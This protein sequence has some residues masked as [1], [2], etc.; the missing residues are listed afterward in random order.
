MDCELFVDIVYFDVELRQKV[1]N[2]LRE[3][4]SCRNPVRVEWL[5][6]LRTSLKGSTVNPPL[7]P[8][9]K[10]SRK[11]SGKPKPSPPPPREVTPKSP[12]RGPATPN[13]TS[14]S[15]HTQPSPTDPPN[16]TK[17]GN[18]TRA[19]SQT[20]GKNVAPEKVTQGGPPDSVDVA[21]TKDPSLSQ[22]TEPEPNQNET[23]RPK[24]PPA[25]SSPDKSTQDPFDESDIESLYASPSP[26]KMNVELD[27]IELE[28]DP[29]FEMMERMLLSHRGPSSQPQFIKKEATA[30]SP[31]LFGA[32]RPLKRQ[33][34]LPSPIGS[35]QVPTQTSQA[36][37]GQAKRP[38]VN[39]PHSSVSAMVLNDRKK[40][41]EFWDLD[42]TVVLQ[43]DDVLFRVMR[44]TLSKASPWFQRLF[45]EEPDHLEIMA[46]CRVYMIE[47]D[48][49]HLDFAN[50]L[51]GLEN[52][53]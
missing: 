27:P 3:T 20:V 35:S 38:R 14:V 11:S 1:E 49:G 17:S 46:G 41:P 34:S 25:K 9:L 51:R 24:G 32:K 44:S 23:A 45:S 40:H 33:R 36:E 2:H 37:F 21:T 7:P 48:F 52:G 26:E 28:S 29:D 10:E 39:G 5:P 47:G 4:A 13:K 8:P 6:R 16:P 43:V 19:A 53:L 22:V 50:L 42:G 15:P 12:P 18:P 30:Q 31:M